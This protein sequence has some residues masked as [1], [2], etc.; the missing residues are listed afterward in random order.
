MEN[1][2]FAMILAPC[3]F[4]LELFKFDIT[5]CIFPYLNQIEINAFIKCIAIQRVQ[6]YDGFSAHVILTDKREFLRRIS[7]V[8]LLHLKICKVQERRGAVLWATLGI[9]ELASY[10][11]SFKLLG[12][13][14]DILGP[15]SR[16]IIRRKDG[17]ARLIVT[18]TE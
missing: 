5:D 14:G 3:Y 10:A 6:Y 2:C 13:V 11:V 18:S 16:I 9:C 8:A 1:C 12:R 7:S 17:K 4:Y 15:H